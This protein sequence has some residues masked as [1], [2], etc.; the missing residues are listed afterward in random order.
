[1]SKSDLEKNMEITSE[2]NVNTEQ[3]LRRKLDLLVKTGAILMESNADCARIYR[4]MERAEAFLGLPEENVHI[5][6]NYNIIMVNLSNQQHSFSKYQR[7]TKHNVEMSII[8]KVSKMLWTAIRE[9]WS[10]DKYEEE[11]DGLKHIKRNYTPWQIAIAA[12]FACGGFCIQFG[13]DW[14]AF[15]YASIAAILGFRL[16]MYL[17][18]KGVNSYVNIAFSAF[19]ATI[20]AWLSSFISLSPN[21]ASVVPAF[22]VSSTPWHPLMACTLFIV[23]GVPMINFVSDVLSD[24][25]QVG[26]T[27]AIITLMTVLAMAF[28]IAFAIQV[29]GIDNFVKNLSMTPHHNYWTFAAAAAIS[30]M[31]FS[32]IYNTPRRI[33]PVLAVGG[34]IAVCTRNFVN[35]GA[36]THNIGLDMGLIVGSFVGSALVSLIATKTCH[37]H[38]IPHQV[39]AIPSVIPMIPGVLMYR[40]LFGFIDMQGG[41][42]ELTVAFTNAIHASLITLFIAIGVAI[43]NIFV[44]RL[45]QPKRKQKLLRLVKERRIK[46]GEMVDLSELD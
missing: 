23:P 1:M 13:C 14:T 42:G 37:F 46:H 31:G 40:S 39:I 28:G 30:A 43:P 20:L 16:K 21:I 17:G 34:I 3:M 27:R 26:L 7:C 12:G 2:T 19:I 4:N 11:L 5:N 35:L 33:L 22:L 29:F 45:I 32:T 44:R 10:L 25:V 24:Y 15:F 9:D 36:S 8:S 6:L 41:A 38:H 18:P